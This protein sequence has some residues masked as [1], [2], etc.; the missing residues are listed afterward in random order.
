M[1][2]PGSA[3]DTDRV[4]SD[5]VHCIGKSQRWRRVSFDRNLRGPR[6]ET[7]KYSGGSDPDVG[8]CS[9]D[10]RITQPWTVSEIYSASQPART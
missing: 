8:N 2:L 10:Q 6:E 1:E 4:Q 9:S 3:M 7:V 5:S